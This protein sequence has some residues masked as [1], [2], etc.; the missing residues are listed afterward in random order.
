[1]SGSENFSKKFGPWEFKTPQRQMHYYYANEKDP[2][3]RFVAEDN[4]NIR[5]QGIRRYW[6]MDVKTLYHTMKQNA[7]NG[8][9]NCFYELMPSSKCTHSDMSACSTMLQHFGT[10]AYLDIEFKDPCDWIEYK[11]TEMDPS[12]IGLKI[13]KNFHAY[14]EKYLDCQCQLLLLK[15]HRAHKKSWHIIAKTFRNGIEYLFRDSL[16]VL[17]L[18][19]AWFADA[20]VAAFDYMESDKRKNAIDNSVYFRHKLFRIYGNQKLGSDSGPLKWD[21][22]YPELAEKVAKPTFEDLFVLQSYENRKMF[23]IVSSDSCLTKQKTSRSRKRRR[24]E[25]TFSHGHLALEQFFFGLPAWKQVK[26]SL[27]ARFSCIDFSIAQ[28]KDVET[29]YIPLRSKQCPFNNG[30]NNGEHRSNHS[31]LYVYMSSGVCFWFCNDEDCKRK[32]L[33]KRIDF[34]MDLTMKMKSLYQRKKE[35]T[36]SI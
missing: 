4:P 31:Y 20:K 18:I 35:I 13:A 3:L 27:Q 25:Q 15:S 17:T 22:Y 19:E 1:M 30:S 36:V 26:E 6:L 21:Q 14:V 7:N 10:R 9:E 12:S 32:K 33:K 34:P 11:T 28:F 5:G 24:V 2:T 29:V 23:D 8:V 16:A